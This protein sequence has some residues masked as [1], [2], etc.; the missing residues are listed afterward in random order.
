MEKAGGPEKARALVNAAEPKNGKTALHFAAENRHCMM[1]S[2]SKALVRPYRLLYFLS[3]IFSIWCLCRCV[4][5]V[6]VLYLCG[7]CVHYR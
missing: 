3:I 6:P 7:V 5:R 1:V 4:V 2:S